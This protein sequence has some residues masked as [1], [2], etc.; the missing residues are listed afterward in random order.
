MSYSLRAS[1]YGS[2][3]RRIAIRQGSFGEPPMSLRSSVTVAGS[4]MSAWRAI[5]VQKGSWT[6]IVSGRGQ[7]PAQ[8]ARSW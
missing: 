7:G 8:A 4:T 6:T 2:T 5:G 3:A 1:P